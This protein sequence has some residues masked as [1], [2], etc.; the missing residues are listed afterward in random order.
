MLLEAQGELLG[1]SHADTSRTVQNICTMC[2]T[3][4]KT[5]IAEEVRQ[6]AKDASDKEKIERSA[7]VKELRS[8]D[9]LRA[10]DEETE[11]T[12]DQGPPT[13]GE[14]LSQIS[15]SILSTGAVPALLLVFSIVGVIFIPLAV[16][17]F[18]YSDTS[19]PPHLAKDST[20]V[21]INGDSEV[22]IT[23]GSRV[24]LS[25]ADSRRDAALIVNGRDARELGELLLN[26]LTKSEYLLRAVPEGLIDSNGR[27][28]F[29]TEAEEFA[30]IK[31][32]E[33]VARAANEFYTR[34]QR[35]PE[36]ID[37]LGDLS[38]E[39]PFTLRKDSPLIQSVTIPAQANAKQYIDGL[40]AGAR[41]EGEAAFY[42]G[43]IN[44]EI[45]R[46]SCRERV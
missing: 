26:P 20:F 7:Q 35:Y 4:G 38:Y 25:G 39:N 12:E 46:A 19:L 5:E 23:S 40:T 43:A 3:L 1:Y 24:S 28:I 18:T 37:Q 44:C 42:P 29:K 13:V 11:D 15:S 6:L 32:Q 30:I 2:V 21:T 27:I 33:E 22:S 10:E 31:Q 9:A 8:R 36:E 14:A 16:L 45:G 17:S 41:W 34:E